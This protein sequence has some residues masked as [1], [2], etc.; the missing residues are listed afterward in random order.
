M[1]LLGRIKSLKVLELRRILQSLDQ[2][3]TGKK[4]DLAEK[5][6]GY[7]KANPHLIS[8]AFPDQEKGVFLSNAVNRISC[9]ILSVAYWLNHFDLLS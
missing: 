1:D 2:D 3:T 5:L 9:S 8:L 6:K 7:L 4:T